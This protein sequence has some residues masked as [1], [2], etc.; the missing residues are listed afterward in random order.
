MKKII[1]LLLSFICSGIISAQVKHAEF[2]GIPIDGLRYSVVNKLIAKGFV[3]TGEYEKN[4]TLKGRFA[5]Y[6]N[7]E[8]TIFHMEPYRDCVTS[9]GVWFNEHLLYSN[10]FEDYKALQKNLSKKYGTPYKVN[11]E[12]NKN[13]DSIYSRYYIPNGRLYLG[14]NCYED[15]YQAYLIYYDDYNQVLYQKFEEEA[16]MNDL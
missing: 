3:K 2:M 12:Q 11:T 4:V 14:I 16:K 10:A 8:L 15:M 9:I 1:L 7:C 6:D 5:G 13:K